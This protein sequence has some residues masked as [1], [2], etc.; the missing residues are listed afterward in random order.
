MR[1][2]FDKIKEE[3]KEVLILPGI[4]C[5]H[6]ACAFCDYHVDRVSTIGEMED[7]WAKILTRVKGHNQLDVYVSGSI[8]EV[9]IYL[10]VNLKEFCFGYRI[11]KLLFEARWD[12][13]HYLGVVRC[14]FAPISVEIWCGVESWDYEEGNTILKKGLI[15]SYPQPELFKDFFDGGFFLVGFPGQ[16]KANII[17]TVDVNKT[18]NIKA[19]YNIFT[20]SNGIK[21]DSKLIGW[22]RSNFSEELGDQINWKGADEYVT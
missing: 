20:E 16:K 8:T 4:G 22:F 5:R 19:K 13:R 6:S 21:P 2:Y 9:P 11:T 15:S 14:L 1:R 12:Y 17:H 7:V 18:H 10:L 3:G